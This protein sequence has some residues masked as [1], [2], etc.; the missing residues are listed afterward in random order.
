MTVHQYDSLVLFTSETP[1]S[2][3]V[4]LQQHKGGG[5]LLQNRYVTIVVNVVN[6]E[7]TFHDKTCCHFTIPH[8]FLALVAAIAAMA[9]PNFV[10]IVPTINFSALQLIRC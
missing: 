4:Y 5:L 6:F 10:P 8:F 3:S 2:V 1:S 7:M 9:Q